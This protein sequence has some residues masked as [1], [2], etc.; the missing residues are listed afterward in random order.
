MAEKKLYR[1]V[2]DF[3]DPTKLDIVERDWWP[4]AGPGWAESRFQ[5]VGMYLS[6]VNRKLVTVSRDLCDFG[7]RK[8]AGLA[9]Y[10]Q[11]QPR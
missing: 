9:L 1:V 7:F 3:S 10:D 2:W 5:A 6:A 11:E 4:T 8:E